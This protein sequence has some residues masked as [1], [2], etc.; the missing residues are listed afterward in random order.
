L[1]IGTRGKAV[2]E[3]KD[4]QRL[5]VGD[6]GRGEAVLDL[7][8]L[9]RGLGPRA[10]PAVRRS[11]FVAEAEEHPLEPAHRRRSIRSAVSGAQ[12]HGSAVRWLCGRGLRAA[13]LVRAA[14]RL[15]M[16]PG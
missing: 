1:P 13:G 11:A 5:G 6:A 2:A 7:E 8:P 9:D 4:A 15:A 14:N 10:E 3:P 16:P 12:S